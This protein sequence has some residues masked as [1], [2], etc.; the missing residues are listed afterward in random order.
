MQF[1]TDAFEE[2]AAIAE[3]CGRMSRFD[4]ESLAAQA[5]GIERWQALKLMRDQAN[6][7]RSGHS[8][9]AS[10]SNAEMAG[11]P[12]QNDMPGMQR[13]QEEK[14]RPLPEHNENAGRD[15][16]LLSTLRTQGRRVV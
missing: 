4:A 2:R 7:N 6:E 8:V 1:D 10:A 11:K 9:G 5:Q 16:V 12:R 3:F 14:K 15:S 13:G